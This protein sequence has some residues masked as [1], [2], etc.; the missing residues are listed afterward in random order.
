MGTI[1]LAV[2]KERLPKIVPYSQKPSGMNDAPAKE[3]SA[4]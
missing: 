4:L 2:Y 3:A 1:A